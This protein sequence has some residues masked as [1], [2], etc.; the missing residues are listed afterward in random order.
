MEGYGVEKG[1]RDQI[2]VLIRN[3]MPTAQPEIQPLLNK[4]WTELNEFFRI[5]LP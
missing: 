3:T 4:S 5:A 1:T 2:L